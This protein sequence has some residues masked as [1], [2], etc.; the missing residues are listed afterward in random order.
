MLALRITL[1]AGTDAPGGDTKVTI[2]K[3]YRDPA[4]RLPWRRHASSEM[5]ETAVLP[6]LR[7][8]GRGAAAL[9]AELRDGLRDLAGRVS[10]ESVRVC[11]D[12]DPA[13][14]RMPWEA[15]L[16]YPVVTGNPPRP[17]ALDFWRWGERLPM[18]GRPNPPHPPR[19]AVVLA[20]SSRRLFAER[21]ALARELSFPDLSARR[22]IDVNL[23]VERVGSAAVD[24][25][26]VVLVIGRPV[27]LENSVL[28]QTTE[29]VATYGISADDLREA[30]VNS[31][32]LEAQVVAG[33]RACLFVVLGAPA[34]SSSRFD[35]ERRDAALLR[36]W[37]A[38]VFRAGT[39]A[40]ISLP[41]LPPQLAEAVLKDI[42]E[43][44]QDGITSR[45]LHAAVRAAR[46]EIRTW[47]QP[48]PTDGD[49]HDGGAAATE[50]QVEQAL[51]VCL[52]RRGRTPDFTTSEERV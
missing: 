46:K 23:A 42:A 15:L 31:G 35:T 11:L 9:P 20:D 52:F 13:L 10:P 39:A 45:A 40:V 25:P 5:T 27:R 36:A 1:P 38:D 7:A 18:T 17:G 14:D 3:R 16:S 44:I 32:P 29:H 49:P 51:D 28:L 2:Q 50:R 26:D 21:T 47:A 19:R 6:P 30:F 43:E 4:S 37:A 24:P 34:E 41:S 33:L 48:A 12:V 8:Y 22:I